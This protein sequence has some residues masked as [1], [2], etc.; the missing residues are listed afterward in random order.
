M[1]WPK[2]PNNKLFLSRK[3]SQPLVALEWENNL[4]I[5]PT[6]QLIQ[7]QT[8]LCRILAL[9]C[10]ICQPSFPSLPD[11][12][13]LSLCNKR[14]WHGLTRAEYQT[15]HNRAFTSKIS[16]TKGLWKYKIGQSIQSLS[17][18]IKSIFTNALVNTLF[19]SSTYSNFTP[20]L[21]L[22]VDLMPPKEWMTHAEQHPVVA[23][24][25][26][27]PGAQLHRA[28]WCR[29]GCTLMGC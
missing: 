22:Y 23:R 16:R 7:I 26:E 25:D 20:V 3:A 28:A 21:P 5:V 27:S 14:C 18:S 8:P 2:G 13:P 4:K 10:W 19:I 15:M 17:K 29:W 9:A 6:G 11:T 24:A 1:A 12:N